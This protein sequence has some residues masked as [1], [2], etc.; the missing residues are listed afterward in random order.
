MFETIAHL[1]NKYLCLYVIAVEKNSIN[2]KTKTSSSFN[3]CEY[4]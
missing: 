1:L 3:N 2:P 4:Q